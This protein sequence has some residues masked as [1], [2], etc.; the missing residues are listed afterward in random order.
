MKGMGKIFQ[1]FKQI[2][3]RYLKKFL[4][5]HLEQKSTN[6]VYN[7][8]TTFSQGGHENV[9]LCGLGFEKKEW[10]GGACDCRLNPD[11]A[12][13]C[14]AFESLYTKDALK[15]VFNDFLEQKELEHISKHYPDLATLMWVLDTLSIEEAEEIEESS[16][17]NEDT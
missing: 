5:D 13:N 8:P 7:R 4:E 14:D 11:L 10:L 6:C 16:Q 15:K 9:F 3:F 2:R 1:R 17:E 12:K